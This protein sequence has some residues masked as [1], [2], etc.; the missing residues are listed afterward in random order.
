MIA[1]KKF[2]NSSFLALA[3]FVMQFS[4]RQNAKRNKFDYHFPKK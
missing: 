4:L 2:M 1:T 3:V